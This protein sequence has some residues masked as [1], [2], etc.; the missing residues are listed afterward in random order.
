MIVHKLFESKWILEY[1][2]ADLIDDDRRYAVYISGKVACH[3]FFDNIQLQVKLLCCL[4]VSN[5]LLLFLLLHQ[6]Y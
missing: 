1:K 6:L 4:L 5:R 2:G 3:D